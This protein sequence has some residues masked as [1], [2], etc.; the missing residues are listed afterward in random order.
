M[1]IL[2]IFLG[3]L[4]LGIVILVH[5]FGHFVAAKASGI[6]VEA[7]SIGWG[8]KIFGFRRGDTEYRISFLPVGGYCKMKGEEMLRSAVAEG[9]DSFPK[10]EGS[11][12]S[13]SPQG[14]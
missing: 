10:D 4:G 2:N 5:E 1:I 12:F 9:S 7:F 3:L 8:K 14:R 6:T 13:V 11:L